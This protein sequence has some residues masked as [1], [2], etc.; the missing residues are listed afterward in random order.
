MVTY[1]PMIGPTTSEWPVTRGL[2]DHSLVK[3]CYFSEQR[4]GEIYLDG[5]KRRRGGGSS[6][7]LDESS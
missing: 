1:I 4:G 2:T 3:G 5:I 6:G 7:L